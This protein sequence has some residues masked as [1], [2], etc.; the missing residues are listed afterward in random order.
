[1]TRFN[2]GCAVVQTKSVIKS[3]H[4]HYI[5]VIHNRY[6]ATLSLYVI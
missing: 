6:G 1:M 4:M 2:E 3:Q 5:L